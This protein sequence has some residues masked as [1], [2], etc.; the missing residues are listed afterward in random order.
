MSF[1]IKNIRK[2]NGI[3]TLSTNDTTADYVLSET[4]SPLDLTRCGIV[5]TNQP[6]LAYE[7]QLFL[8]KFPIFSN[9]LSESF[10]VTDYQCNFLNISSNMPNFIEYQGSTS[11]KFIVKIKTDNNIPLKLFHISMILQLPNNQTESHT[12][13]PDEIVTNTDNTSEYNYIQKFTITLK[14]KD[15]ITFYLYEKEIKNTNQKGKIVIIPSI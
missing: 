3:K 7:A 13:L 9:F 12:I 15:G 10:K 8:C 11:Q 2:V 14:P 1:V 6:Y 5:I 4:I